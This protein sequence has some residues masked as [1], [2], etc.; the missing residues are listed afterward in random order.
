MSSR[1]Y[2]AV[3]A[4]LVGGAIFFVARNEDDPRLE[5]RVDAFSKMADECVYS[6]RDRGQ[7]YDQSAS[8]ASLSTHATAYLEAGGGVT[9]TPLKY[10]VRFQAALRVAWSALAMSESCGRRPLSLW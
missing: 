5:A 9:K 4:L 2:L 3:L 7:K 1:W 8:C 10:E 6:V